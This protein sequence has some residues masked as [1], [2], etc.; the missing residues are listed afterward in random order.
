MDEVRVAG[1]ILSL[2]LVLYFFMALFF[3]VFQFKFDFSS[4]MSKG[5]RYAP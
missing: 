2:F 5:S 3:T 1:L 4:T